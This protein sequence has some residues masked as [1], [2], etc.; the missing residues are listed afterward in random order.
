[1]QGY[2]FPLR[3]QVY[4]ITIYL[5]LR[6]MDF[7][8]ILG[9]T[10]L[11]QGVKI[12]KLKH[13]LAAALFCFSTVLPVAAEES[14]QNSTPVTMT[15]N[16][17]LIQTDAKP[18][19]HK[20][21]TYV[22]IRFVS[23]ALGADSVTW[24]SKSNTAV[25]VHEGDT[26][27]LARG[28][29]NAYI[30]GKYVPMTSSVQLVNDRLFVPARFVAEA[31]GC[32]VDWVYD[33]YTVAITKPGATVPQELIADRS[34]TDDEI[35]WL[36]KIIHAESQ[37]EPMEGK[38]AVANVILNR[39]KSDDYPNTIYDVIFD[40]KHGVQFSPIL[41]GTIYHD[42]YGDSII[43]AKRALEGENPVGDC[44]FFLN[45]KSAT[46]FWIT[47]NRTFYTTIQNHDF[48]L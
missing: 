40:T 16:D 8:V 32:T 42:P 13:W 45:P 44:L 28:Q 15:V 47:N 3:K 38:I 4:I 14:I 43:A 22:P 37:G 31:L 18:F 21:I 30:N 20:G 11:L 35:Y 7:Y 19:L 6:R 2:I 26:I 33:T 25:I 12:M 5:P 9:T 34:Y 29:N 27:T 41:N 10:L 1:M 24:N 39:T 46:S 17:C 48:Y 36:S 23:E